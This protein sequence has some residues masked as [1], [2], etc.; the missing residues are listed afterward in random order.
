MVYPG[1]QIPDIM[2]IDTYFSEDYSIILDSFE[3]R[4]RK[5]LYDFILRIESIVKAN[6]YMKTIYFH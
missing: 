4:S 1:K 5:V 3:E 2:M 6:Q